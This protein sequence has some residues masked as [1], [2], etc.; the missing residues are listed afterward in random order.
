MSQRSS[1]RRARRRIG[2]YTHKNMKSI[3]G[4]MT[5]Y[6]DTSKYDTK[7]A[8]TY[9]E[10]TYDGIK[11]LSEYL[12]RIRPITSYPISHRVFYDLGSGIGKNVIM[13]ASMNPQ[14]YAKGIELVNERHNMAMAAYRNI[15]EKSVKSRVEF[16]N[17]SLFDR[18]LSDASWIYISNL[19]FSSEIN[20][21]LSEKLGKELQPNAIIV[22]SKPLEHPSLKLKEQINIPMTW[23]SSSMV[24]VYQKAL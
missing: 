24:F 23:D 15:K 22:C 7:Y 21:Q 18:S 20:D 9:G 6:M 12:N 1:T 2:G 17:G 13:M 11:Y 16:I 5:G 14:L 10:V 19:C 3:Y 8:L 4:S